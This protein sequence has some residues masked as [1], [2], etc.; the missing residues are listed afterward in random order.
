[1]EFEKCGDMSRD[2]YKR[3]LQRNIAYYEDGGPGNLVELFNLPHREGE[4][5]G[6]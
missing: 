1:M 5:L 2:V 4:L 6:P 3:L